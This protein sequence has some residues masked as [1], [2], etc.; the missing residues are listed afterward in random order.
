MSDSLELEPYL[1]FW[2]QRQAEDRQYNQQLGDQA[3]QD[4]GRIATMLQ[5]QFQAQQI[6]LFGSLAKN[7]FTPT[8]DIDLAISGVAP[9]LFFTALAEANRL[10]PFPVDLKTNRSI[11]Q[12]F[13]QTCIGNRDGFRMKQLPA[14][15]CV[16]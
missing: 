4:A 8:S 1:T 15:N 12:S 16:G 2:L 6:I 10:T 14:T 7:K 13:S 11:G 9:E 5:E 3:R